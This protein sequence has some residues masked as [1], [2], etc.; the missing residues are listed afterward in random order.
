MNW[1]NKIILAFIG[2]VGL[3]FVLVYVSVNTEFNLVEED[4]YEK[5]LAYE[6][7]MQRIRNH[8]ALEVK[9]VFEIDRKA[10]L[11]RLTFP[12][13]IVKNMVNGKLT[14]YRANTTRHDKELKIEPDANGEFIIDI[15]EFPVG[16][17]KVKISWSDKEKE[18][19]KEIAFVI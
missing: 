6:S 9:P 7:Q 17:W 4:Y 16:A 12:E 5:E 13:S 2:F 11:T 8:N 10:F 14:F 18:Y 3:I 15:S 19:Y 1:G